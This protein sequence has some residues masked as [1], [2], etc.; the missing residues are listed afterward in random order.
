MT[1]NLKSTLR[2]GVLLLVP[3]AAAAAETLPN[4]PLIV[5][6]ITVG[7]PRRPGDCPEG[8]SDDPAVL[9]VEG[10]A[11]SFEKGRYYPPQEVAAAY[12]RAAGVEFWA[13]RHPCAALVKDRLAAAKLRLGETLS[14]SLDKDSFVLAGNLGLFERRLAALE[15]RLERARS[16]GRLDEERAALKED[17]VGGFA[18]NGGLL[19]QMYVALFRG[20]LA[21]D[22]PGDPLVARWL[23][24]G[25]NPAAA[26]LARLAP[27]VARFEEA[28]GL[29]TGARPTRKP[30]PVPAKPAEDLASVGM[31][32]LTPDVRALE[33]AAGELAAATKPVLPPTLAR[34]A[35]APRPP[36]PSTGTAE[37]GRRFLGAEWHRSLYGAGEWA[38]ELK[39]RLAASVKNSLGLTRTV[40]DPDGRSPLVHRQ[41]WQ[42][43]AV[44]AQQQVLEFLGLVP[45][46]PRSAVER[47][48]A[49]QTSPGGRVLDAG[50]PYKDMGRVLVERGVPVR[51]H[52]RAD[53]QEFLDAAASGR[54]LVVTVDTAGFYRR[55][56]TQGLHA[57]LVTG[58]EVDADGRVVG[59][60]LNDS[61]T[62]EGS[63]YVPVERFL[64]PF[65][66]AK[67]EF[68]E[69]L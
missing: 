46:G 32:G 44:V 42:T 68:L 50:T 67:G 19:L 18:G 65:R 11:A 33:A 13:L 31:P 62:G 6:D 61:A 21:A 29:E 20:T 10:L 34:V 16:A 56:G 14:E 3:A 25:V 47:I 63:R 24:E 30:D 8:F 5:P 23:A 1:K 51:A 48:L 54:M 27:R 53:D 37:D 38:E 26:T 69:V 45:Q 59:L 9:E 43:C 7:A 58:A 49:E 15:R 60:F 2:A 64:P 4:R 41:S 36:E 57:V 17:Y 40:G 39:D 55:L 22:D 52:P 28:V 35:T 66:M 12:H